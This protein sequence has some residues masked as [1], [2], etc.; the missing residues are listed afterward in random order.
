MHQ[1]RGGLLIVR[2]P[3]RLRLKAFMEEGKYLLGKIQ[4]QM[5]FVL[6]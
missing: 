3:P 5:V 6:R 4:I 1:Q 2:S